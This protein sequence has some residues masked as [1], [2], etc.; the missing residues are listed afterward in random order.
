MTNKKQTRRA[1]WMSVVSLILCCTMF[2]GTTFAWFTDSVSSM[3]NVITAGNLDVELTH[4]NDSVADE[5]VQNTEKLFKDVTL[6]EPGVVAYETLTVKNAGTLALKYQLALNFVSDGA[7]PEGKTLADALQ[8]GVIDGTVTEGVTREEL[9]KAV[10]DEDAWMSL[11]SF[12][13]RGELY[14][15]GTEGKDS[16]KIYTVVIYWEPTANDNDFNMNN[17][18]QAIDLSIN[19]GV[20]LFATQLMYEEDSFDATY[21]AETEVFTV[22]EANAKLAANENVTLTNCVDV[23]GIIVIPA[24]YTG[25]FILKDS[26]IKSV[27]AAGDAEITILGNVIVDAKAQGGIMTLA[28]NDFNGSAITANGKLT[29]NGNGTL[30][31]IAAD[32]IGAFGIG[33]M[34]TTEINIKGITIAY[35]SGGYAYGVGND[36]KYYKDAPEG[37]AAIGSS[38]D[39]A[40]ITLDGVTIEKAIGGSKAAGIGARYHVGVTVNIENSTIKYVEGGVSAAG[41]GGSRVSGEAKESGTTINITNS[42]ITAQGGAYGAGIGSGYDTH[43]LK[44]QPLCTINITDSTIEAK[45]GQY[46]AGVGTGYHNAALAGMIKGSTVTA[47]SGDKFYKDTYTEAMDIGFGVVDPSRE[48][49]QTGSYLVYNDEVILL[50][51]SA[52][53]IVK[54]NDELVAAINHA[55]DG[56]TILVAEGEYALRFTNNTSFNVDGLTIVGVGNVKLAVSSSEVWY[57]RVQG[58]NVTFDNIHFT[59]SVGATGKATYNNCTFA[60]WTI[61]ASSNN[62][63]T[64]FNN[65]VING[66]LNTSTDFSAGNTYVTNSTIAKAEYSGSASMNFENCQIGELITWNMNT[67]LN[68]CDVETLNLDNVS[69]ATI[70][71]D[72]KQYVADGLFFNGVDTYYVTSAAGLTA[73][74]NIV[75]TTTPYTPTIFDNATVLLM[76]DIDLENKEWI[77]IGDDRSQRTEFHGVFDGQG[78]TISNVKITKKTDRDD[79]DKSSYGL[80][81]NLKGTVKNLTV[82]K[83]NISGAPKFIGA[84][85]GRM[86]DGLIENCH[87]INSN[88][89]CN[90]WTIGALVG[91]FNNGKISGCTVTNT[92]VAGYGAVG[93]IVGIALNTGERTIENCK[94]ENCNI[95]QNGSFGGNYDKMFGTI[96]GALYNG[97]LTVN[98]NGCTSVNNNIEDLYGY[99]AEGDKLIIDGVQVVLP[100]TVVYDGTSG[101]Q[102]TLNSLNSGDTLILP[103]NTYNTSGTWI[104]PA[105]VVIEGDEM[106]GTVLH[107]NSAAQDNI[108]NCE[109]DVTIKNITF[110]SNRKGYAVTDNTKNH[111]TDGDITLIGCTFKGLATEKNWG[112]YKN[113]N[114][115]L[116]IK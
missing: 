68:N 11:Q 19:L 28:E 20:N 64:Y 49:Q 104:V 102:D 76:N 44:K 63:E 15:A 107:Q 51:G 65:C 67:T 70:I 100:K 46:A 81:G 41:I 92:T 115:N 30:T 62:E 109:G 35:V 36:T 113:L 29:I 47:V 1:L 31:A 52:T 12:A 84:L 66:C 23:N 86:N 106:G 74:A 97:S 18:N 94:V 9:V 103:A 96:V 108:F 5:D 24:N 79:A 71:I 42:T 25:K 53:K 78:H 112:V 61:C 3:N 54:T 6:W 40:V 10:D 8:I 93:G 22:A 116:T 89:A 16:E 91:Q 7:T 57:G 48:G 37:G 80:F 110:E 17:Q 105:G 111:D 38:R 85:V 90:N 45:G 82:D 83:V 26:T 87:V 13:K 77:P 32:E 101:I 58:S 34:K 114:G 14:P 95:V 88:V 50:P 43:C 27:Q 2:V 59:S 4:T 69:T 55:A 33:G 73:V 39:G 56:D 21:D 98:L 72:G 60:D 99:F 75:N